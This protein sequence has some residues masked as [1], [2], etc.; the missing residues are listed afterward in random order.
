[1]FGPHLKRLSEGTIS[2]EFIKLRGTMNRM[3]LVDII[4][5][6][7]DKEKGIT[8]INWSPGS[9]FVSYEDIYREARVILHHLQAKGLHPGN[10]LIFQLEDNYDF[11]TIFWACIMGKIIPVPI[12]LA[13]HP[14][15][16]LKLFN[17]W[18]Q[19]KNP[20]LVTVEKHLEILA[21]FAGV[22]ENQEL[23][24]L[25]QQVKARTITLEEMKQKGGKGTLYIPRETDIAFIQFSSGSTGSPKGVVLTHKNLVTNIKAIIKGTKLTGEQKYFSWMPLTHDM[26]LIGLHLVPFAAGW[27]QCLMKTQLFVRNPGLWL[28]KIS[29]TRSTV[30]GSPNF[31][32]QYVLK[33]FNPGKYKGVD[34]SCLNIIF[35]G[36][37]PISAAISNKFLDCMARFGLART[38]MHPCY[39]LAEASLAVTLSQP[40]KEMIYPYFDRNS[41]NIGGKVK[42]KNK[43]TNGVPVVDVGKPVADCLLKVIDDRGKECKDEIIGHIV[44]KGDNVTSGYYN[45]PQATA[46]AFTSDGWLRTGDLGFLRNKHLFI[47]G[48]AK[49]IL[50]YRGMNYYPHDIERTAEELEEIGFEKIAACGIYNDQTQTDEIICFV[51]YKRKLIDF[52][53]LAAALKEHIRENMN[54]EISRL[55]PVKA[56]P[57][58]TSGKIQRYT[59]K[60]EYLQG[61]YNPV[62]RQ[63]EQMQEK[64]N[65]PKQ[66]LTQ[67]EIE[68]LVI[69]SW[70]QILGKDTIARDENFFTA[71]GDSSTALRVTAKIQEKSGRKLEDVILFKYP[72]IN[73]LTAYLSAAS[74]YDSFHH[75]TSLTQTTTKKYL[76][77]GTG[78]NGLEIAII[79]MSGR[80]PGAGNLDEFWEN[81]KNGLESISFFNEAELIRGGVQPQLL[82]NPNY[83]K[84]RGEVPGIDYFDADFFGYTPRETAEL[85]PQV[86]VLHECLWETLENAGYEPETYKGLIGV[87]VGASP[88]HFWETRS[89]LSGRTGE[90]EQFTD[91]QFN[92]KDFM[93]TQSSYKLNLRGPSYTLYTACSTSLAA[94]DLAIQGILTGRC[95]MALAGGVSIWMPQRSGYLYEESMVFSRDGHNRTFDARA[96][97]TV[98]SDGAGI[99]ALKRLDRAI[100]DNDYI[101]AVIKGAAVNNDGNRKVG[102]TAPAVE[103]QAEVIALAREMAGIEP[104][105]ISYVE[106]HGTATT[107]GDPIEIEALTAAFNTPKKGCCALGSVKANVGHLNAAAGIVGLIKTLLALKHHLIPPTINFENPNP[108]IDFE[109]S[110]FYI[111]TRL[112]EWKRGKTP[113]RAGISSF[114]IGG[115]NVHLVLEEW[116]G[117]PD[118]GIHPPTPGAQEGPGTRSQSPPLGTGQYQLIL[119]S[120][121]T[122]TALDRITENLSHYLK[123]NPNINLADVAYTLQAGRR[124]FQHRKML[125]CS[126]AAEAAT[127]L[128]STMN[129]SVPA[130][131]NL[132]TAV[133]KKPDPPVIFMFSGQGSQYVNM[134]LGLYQQETIF[135]KEIDQCCEILETLMGENIRD[136]L[137]PG[138]NLEKAKEKIND[139]IYSGPVKFVFEYALARQL[140]SWGIRPQAMIGH[141]FGEYT[142][143]CTAGVF[144][145]EQA[146]KLVVPR[147][148]LMKK[149]PRGIMMSVPLPGDEIKPL[150]K[151]N[152]SLAALNTPTRCIVS[153][154]ARPV[155]TLE[156]ELNKK[157]IECMRLNFPR[158]SHSHMMKPI[159]KEFQE[160]V[161]R[162]VL[163]PP[164]IPYIS[165]ITGKWITPG[166]AADPGYW[167]RHLIETV[168][169]SEGIKEL[170]KQPGAIF[171]QV[172]PDRGLPLFVSQHQGIGTG[173]LALNLV[174]HEKEEIPD[175]YYLL[176]KVGQLWLQGVTPDWGSFQAQEKRNRI[177]LPTYPFARQRC[178][179]EPAAPRAGNNAKPWGSPDNPQKEITHWY[180]IPSWQRA[181]LPPVKNN[182]TGYPFAPGWLIFIDN[183]GLGSRLANELQKQGQEVITVTA[184][185][186]FSSPTPH[187]YIMNPC[188]YE[189]YNLLYKEMQTRNQNPGTIVHLWNITAGPGKSSEPKP[190]TVERTINLGFHS[191]LYLVKAI[192]KQEITRKIQLGIVSNN[193]QE[194]VGGDG[195]YPE[196]AVIIGP[197][198]LIN[199]EYPNIRCIS[200][201]IVLDSPGIETISTQIL[202]EIANANPHPLHVVAYRGNYRWMQVFVPYPLEKPVGQAPRLKEKGVYL[203]TG[204]LG[205]IGLILAEYLAKHV[206]ARLI[207]TGRTP[208][209]PRQEWRQQA[210]KNEDNEITGKIRK[211]LE[212]EKLGAEIVVHTADITSQT[213]MQ[214]VFTRA[215][216]EFGPING[217]IQAA[218]VLDH[219]IMQIREKQES[220]RVMAPKIKGTLVID[221]ILKEK[222]KKPDF[223]LLC[224]SIGAILPGVGLVGYS[225]ANAFLDAYANFKSLT[226]D[227]FTL[228]INWPIWEN[229]GL[230][231]LAEKQ[232]QGLKRER[233]VRGITPGEGVEAF[234]RLL[235]NKMPQVVV[236]PHDLDRFIEQW[237]TM[238]KSPPG[239]DTN[240]NL[241]PGTRRRRPG[242]AVEY[243]APGNKSEQILA[244]IWAN[245][246]GYEKIGIQDDFFQLGGDSLKAISIIT[247]LNREMNI[248]VPLN[249]FFENPTIKGIAQYINSRKPSIYQS[250]EPVE[251]K[252][253]YETTIG[254]KKLF[255]LEQME[256]IGVTVNVFNIITIEGQLERNRFEK[257]WQELIKRQE[258]F[259]TSFHTI[260]GEIV[261]R[262]HEAAQIDFAIE[263]VEIQKNWEKEIDEIVKTFNIPFH[264]SQPP[265]LRVA[266]VKLEEQ[267]HMIL[268]DT[269]HIVSDNASLRIM[270][271]EIAL[272]YQ[273]VK[274]PALKLQSK[275]YAVWQQ[276][277][278]K[279][280]GFKNMEN[281]WKEKFSGKVS[282]IQMPTDYPRPKIQRYEG[283][284]LCFHLEKQLLQKIKKLEQ[285]SSATMYMILLAVLNVLLS[286]YTQQEEIT[287]AS[288]GAGRDHS[289]LENIVGLFINLLPMRNYPQPHK[290]FSGFLNEVKENAL[291][292]YENQAYPFG[293]I[294]ENLAIQKDYSRN[295]LNDIELIMVNPDMPAAACQELRFI[296]YNYKTRTVMVDM[297]L[298]VSQS[299]GKISINLAYSTSLFKRETMERFIRSFKQALQAV[300][301]NKDI[302]LKDIPIANP[303]EE[304]QPSFNAEAGDFDF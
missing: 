75:T 44:I 57:K 77:Q 151:D 127:A 258:S 90:S 155:K 76:Q 41:L 139:V 70:R 168:R 54:L 91:I 120:A 106:T 208:F 124:H 40:G 20:Y 261:T 69:E 234:V 201:D 14:Q 251:K 242:L 221:E 26:G 303:L 146:L 184:G 80:F 31:G 83:V 206:R 43:E 62:I 66:N 111:N 296:P 33:H 302:L 254:Q 195:K 233:L 158:A 232:Y 253:F 228:S 211:L 219:N 304:A 298:S 217:I 117:Q 178:Q 259:R 36:A 116:P 177:P 297:I 39:G 115:T 295:P 247:Q 240:E 156:K 121:R 262:I 279:T 285:Q 21:Q 32:Y 126:Q 275:D 174:R 225:S 165:G 93:A 67:W 118:P 284:G 2:T 260:D 1:M 301:E 147:G 18:P 58:T 167:A 98:F 196:K 23:F 223:F 53:P 5:N 119:L 46:G 291:A 200:I 112:K 85:D 289:G 108:R 63:L 300:G 190:D 102:Y 181:P 131:G 294:I 52:L 140:M 299:A 143:A 9:Y 274:L 141:S 269:H 104:A 133:V 81:I 215:E 287:I 273:G 194:V 192:G 10:E 278:I 59:L 12:T 50:F 138:N 15:F 235:A 270:L 65:A 82:E 4:L 22:K 110:P 7:Q 161:S 265:L 149:M 244:K 222:E 213:R 8:F 100:A 248:K 164:K 264:L 88:N 250:I 197:C 185:E 189:H 105:S 154:P 97:G 179:E 272:L 56:I 130:P 283:E 103:G 72:T 207:L 252:Q 55:V 209:P 135:R 203:I 60:N 99:V 292:A 134:G 205:G 64:I 6:R 25:F 142:A 266:L 38:A 169:F 263:Y 89:L 293:K 249:I 187:T 288:P 71:G 78:K 290:T 160:N 199:R 229:I 96:S 11:V 19:L 231:S 241:N 182:K 282:L 113:R 162:A 45:N 132:F 230:A 13:T 170:L 237:Q 101:Y 277:F 220:D 226:G 218:G 216:A 87:Y 35:N 202:A 176:E 166:E 280:K 49:E 144:S 95:D 163:N 123:Q 255:V 17:I 257:A 37:E 137:Y 171:V 125:L 188:V 191:L 145:P 186:K 136:I 150:I 238:K 210:S 114:G 109:S 68:K 212:L 47:T 24:A 153:G 86:R 245:V 183:S 48:R 122:Q 159:L 204:G 236:C 42:E 193:M 61:K 281:H 256:N 157:G 243:I 224:S 267:K 92:D 175:V 34:L 29:E 268:L 27:N 28:E 286:N 239:Q 3:N 30:T 246:L 173:N 79:G 276:K 51:V 227:I 198:R 16:K 107:L 74:T 94:V 152:I 172:G 214:E 148:R 84:A 271:T 129:S 180:Y 128:S 73:A